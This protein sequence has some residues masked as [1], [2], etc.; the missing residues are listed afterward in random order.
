M[1][2]LLF[3]VYFIFRKF[4][5]LL[6]RIVPITLGHFIVNPRSVQLATFTISTDAKWQK[7]RSILNRNLFFQQQFYF[8]FEEHIE[9]KV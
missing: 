8:N 3:Q 1:K 4:D 7:L 2:R 6:N 5:H 9:R